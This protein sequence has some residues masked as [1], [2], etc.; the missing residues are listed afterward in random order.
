M[1]I[2]YIFIKGNLCFCINHKNKNNNALFLK[3]KSGRI[4]YYLIKSEYNYIYIARKYKF[5]N[6][7]DLV[8]HYSNNS[9]IFLILYYI[10][11]LII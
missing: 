7:E 10:I 4:Q 1:N 8:E 3:I 6:L 2:S 5:Y 11:N 9:G